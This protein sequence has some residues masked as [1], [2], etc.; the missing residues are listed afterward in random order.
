MDFLC[1]SLTVIVAFIADQGRWLFHTASLQKRQW[2]L[3]QRN[4]HLWARGEKQ[5]TERAA[6]AYAVVITTHYWAESVCQPHNA[7]QGFILVLG[8]LVFL[9]G[10]VW[11]FK[12]I[13][14]G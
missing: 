10:W 3:L 1:Y 14:W 9:V 6:C 8:C 7:P 11:F 13:N 4:C 2:S 12:M 5:G